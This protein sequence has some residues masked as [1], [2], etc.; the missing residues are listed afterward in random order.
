M[1][2]AGLIAGIAGAAAAA[3]LLAAQLGGTEAPGP[4]W[5]LA[6]Y[7]HVDTAVQLYGVRVLDLPAIAGAIGI[8]VAIAFI[9]AWLP[10]VRATRVEP[11]SVLRHE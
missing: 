10:A 6:R 5:S 8:L 4:R 11:A 1:V 9:A 7:E 2:T 3:R